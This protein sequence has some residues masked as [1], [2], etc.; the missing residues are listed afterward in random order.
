MAELLTIDLNVARDFLDP[1]R[2]GHRAAVEL[3]AL[4]GEAVELAIGPQGRRVDAPEGR[5]VK[6]LDA[7]REEE[8]VRELRQLAYLSEATL[9][10]EDL[11]PGQYV[12]GFREAW[13]QII[14]TWKT[15]DG[16]APEHPDDFHVEAHLLEERDVFIS[17]DRALQEMCRRLREEH[18]LAIR[19]MSI[20]EYLG[21]RESAR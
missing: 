1:R 18:G 12:E 4:N 3:F 15:S 2:N 20:E 17:A 10:S 21:S 19:A 8:S 5:L 9:P 11:Y 13:G 6:E 16:R 14:E 7:M